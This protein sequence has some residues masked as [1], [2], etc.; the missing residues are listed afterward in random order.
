MQSVSYILLEYGCPECGE[1]IESLEPR[2]EPAQAVVH[3]GVPA[4]RV[5]SAP[6]VKTPLYSVAKAGREDSKPAPGQYN[7]QGIREG[8]RLTE[9]RAKRAAERKRENRDR[10]H[11]WVKDL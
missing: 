2:S 1:R 6:R 4:P 5:L 11:K 8:M 10:W 9:W 7:T 3:C